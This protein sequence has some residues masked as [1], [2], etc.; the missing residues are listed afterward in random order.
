MLWSENPLVEW[1]TVDSVGSG[2]ACATAYG[3]GVWV[4]VE[5]YLVANYTHYHIFAAPKLPT[6]TTDGAYTYIRAK[7]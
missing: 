3:D 7:E 5:S 1:K 6:I 4:T 2:F